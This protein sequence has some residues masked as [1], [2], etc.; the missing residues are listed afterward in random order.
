MYMKL[1]GEKESGQNPVFFMPDDLHG[2][3]IS[4]SVPERWDFCHQQYIWLYLPSNWCY[5][6]DHI[7]GQICS[8]E[9]LF[10]HHGSY[11]RSKQKLWPGGLLP[12]T[13]WCINCRLIGLGNFDYSDSC[14][15]HCIAMRLPLKTIWILQLIQTAEAHLLPGVAGLTS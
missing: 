3:R 11:W 6:W 7:N 8:L 13:N 15:C 4:D 10:Y 1:L 12:N 14:L 9:V 2:I 5:L